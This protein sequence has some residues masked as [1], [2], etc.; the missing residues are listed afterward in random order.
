MTKK[1]LMP[2]LFNFAN[3][4]FLKIATLEGQPLKFE[5]YNLAIES[6]DESLYTNLKPFDCLGN[7]QT[8]VG[9]V[10]CWLHCRRPTVKLDITDTFGCSRQ[11]SSEVIWTQSLSV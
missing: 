2:N 7:C 5:L 1:N 6:V 3:I 9:F 8:C 4:P 11:L 10:N